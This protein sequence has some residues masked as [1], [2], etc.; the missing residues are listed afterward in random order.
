MRW[1][2]ALGLIAGLAVG[3]AVPVQAADTIT[4]TFSYD[5]DNPDPAQDFR[6]FEGHV[7]AGR[8]AQSPAGFNDS[9]WSG[10][11]SM[12]VFSPETSGTR[13][14]IMQ[15]IGWEDEVAGLPISNASIRMHV[16]YNANSEEKAG[17]E[18]VVNVRPML[19]PVNIGNGDGLAPPPAARPDLSDR[20]M[21]NQDMGW[22]TWEHRAADIMDVETGGVHT[23]AVG[24]GDGSFLQSHNG[25]VEGIDYASSPMATTIVAPD[26]ADVESPDNDGDGVS[27]YSPVDIDLTSI[28]QWWQAGNTNNGLHFWGETGAGGEA[29]PP[30][31]NTRLYLHGSDSPDSGW[32]SAVGIGDG[33]KP[34]R[35]AILSITTVP[36]PATLGLLCLGG[37]VALRRTRR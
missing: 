36:E 3:F 11:D 5:P 13:M 27:D 17:W 8:S 16:R 10:G 28:F 26:F 31:A 30:S 32:G 7:R 21:P 14:G 24:W 2:I 6:Q 18:Q 22:M 20:G 4:H 1:T 15:L 29:D 34:R 25:P 12:Q 9:N 35:Y 33:F 37:L 23:S 19:V